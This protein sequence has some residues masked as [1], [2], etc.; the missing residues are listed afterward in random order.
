MNINI[1]L[2]SIAIISSL[3]YKNAYHNMKLTC[4]NYVLNT[5]LYIILSLL[6]VS[7]IVQY[8]DKHYGVSILLNMRGW[9]FLILFILVIISMIVSMFLSPDKTFLKHLF[10]IIFIILIGVTLYPAYVIGKNSG[11]LTSTILTTIMIVFLLTMV[12]FYNPDLISL[13]WGP[14][15]TI[16]LSIGIILRIL[17]YFLGNSNYNYYSVII[18]YIFI[19][20]FSFL[21]LYDTKKLQINAKHC[22]IPDYIN[23]SIGIFLDIINLFQNILHIKSSQ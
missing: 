8:I 23:E 18:S 3:I 4:K 20:I 12:A 21:I 16:M 7:F 5:Y 6:I 13:N 2:I 10:W 1:L 9:K 11:I 17:L 15:L 22:V 19:T 14:V